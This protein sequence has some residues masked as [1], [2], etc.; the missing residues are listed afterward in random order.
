MEG[1]NSSGMASTS[2][3][4]TFPQS[5]PPN[6]FHPGLHEPIYFPDAHTILPDNPPTPLPYQK[7]VPWFLQHKR[8]RMTPSHEFYQSQP[9]NYN[10]DYQAF[11]P[12][13]GSTG[14]YE[15]EVDT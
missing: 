5:N 3:S 13:N 7:E 1:F 12:Q 8:R 9:A 11:G 15:S 2:F 6:S 10:M 14:V 4:S